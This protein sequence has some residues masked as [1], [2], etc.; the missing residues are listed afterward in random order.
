MTTIAS[1]RVQLRSAELSLAC[2]EMI[3]DWDRRAKEVGYWA[4]RVEHLKTELA[5]ADPFNPFGSGPV[6]IEERRI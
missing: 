5:A 1:L 6:P 2:A 4:G 3:D